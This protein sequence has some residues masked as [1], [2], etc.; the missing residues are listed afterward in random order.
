AAPGWP[1]SRVSASASS[2][3][4]QPPSVPN[5]LRSVPPC[6]VRCWTFS[7]RIPSIPA[8]AFSHGTPLYRSAVPEAFDFAG[9]GDLF[10]Y[11]QPVQICLPTHLSRAAVPERDCPVVETLHRSK[12]LSCALVL[13]QSRAS[14][15]DG[16]HHG[17]GECI[18]S[19]LCIS[20]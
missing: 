12:N 19:H 11:A 14:N 2:I 20:L 10:P 1:L 7:I 13:C 18:R 6:C 17:N 16:Q 4:G 8:L 15:P 9:E 5:L 3:T